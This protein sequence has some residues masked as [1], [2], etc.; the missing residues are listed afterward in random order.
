MSAQKRPVALRLPDLHTFFIAI[1]PRCLT[2]VKKRYAMMV[3]I[4]YP[5]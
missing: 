4:R 3:Q 1:T 2:F 5:N